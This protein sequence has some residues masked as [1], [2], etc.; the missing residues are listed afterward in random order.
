[1]LLRLWLSKFS[2]FCVTFRLRLHILLLNW[3]CISCSHW[4]YASP[5]LVFK[6]WDD[7]HVT[8]WLQ[9]IQILSFLFP[10]QL[11]QCPWYWRIQNTFLKRNWVP[12]FVIFSYISPFYFMFLHAKAKTVTLSEFPA[13]DLFSFNFGLVYKKPRRSFQM[14]FLHTVIKE[15]LN[16]QKPVYKRY[17]KYCLSYQHAIHNNACIVGSL[18]TN[19]LWWTLQKCANN[20]KWYVYNRILLE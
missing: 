11:D 19:V 17:I 9:S 5:S 15:V 4:T 7:R 6:C 10:M 3:R 16:F 1:M 14:F 18:S 13:W 8:P 20:H 2:T 12:D